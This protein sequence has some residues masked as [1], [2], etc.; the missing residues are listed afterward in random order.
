MTGEI[1]AQVFVN[2]IVLSLIYVLMALGLTLVFSI[3]SMINFAHGEIYM[4]GAF[5]VYYVFDQ[6]H[7]SYVWA[8]IASM[9][10]SAIAGLF[11]ERFIFRPLRGKPGFTLAS[12]LASLG[13][14]F[15]VASAAQL[16]F[17]EKDKD[18]ATVI[19]GVLKLGTVVFSYEKLLVVVIGIVLTIALI[20]VIR[21]SKL[22]HALQAI[23]QERDA[24][25]L[26]GIN[27]NRLNAIGFALASALA[28][29]AGGLIAP[30]FFISPYIGDDVVLK[31]FI[32]VILGGLGS[33][34]GAVIAGFILGFVDS[35][36]LTLIGYSANIIGFAIVIIF[37]IF[38]HRGLLGREFRVH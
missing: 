11:L 21:Y 15:M 22:G 8:L 16:I 10:V 30:L 4:L 29:A 35:F 5:A 25:A 17:G 23:A 13:V 20:L 31:A 1:L 27:I 28:G 33:L 38:R 24:A 36:G 3:M 19:S 14:G 6:W 12:C 2:A 34:S 7:L 9:V 32:I 26:M 37:L 18:V